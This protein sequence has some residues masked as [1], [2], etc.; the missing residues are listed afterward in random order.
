MEGPSYPD[1]VDADLKAIRSTFRLVWNPK[2]VI[3]KPGSIDAN[4]FIVPPTYDGR[5]ELWDTDAEGA[6]YR[7]MRVQTDGGEFRQPGEW[8]VSLLKLLNP[9]RWGGDPGRM[10]QEMVDNH[11]EQLRQLAEKDFE[12]LIEMATRSYLEYYQVKNIG[13]P[14][15]NK[16]P[17]EA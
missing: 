4:G 10:I 11:N 5:Y 2:S 16:R 3:A 15:V 13:R 17:V 6:D 8:L 1:Y 12:D 9:E 7:V 14:Q